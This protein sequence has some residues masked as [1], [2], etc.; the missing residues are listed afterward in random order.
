[1][2]IYTIKY[3]IFN[4]K[5]MSQYE[6]YNKFISRNFKVYTYL[7]FRLNSNQLNSLSSKEIVVK[8]SSAM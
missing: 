7:S 5:K 4:R 1:M 3:M 6:Y 8:Q 2:D